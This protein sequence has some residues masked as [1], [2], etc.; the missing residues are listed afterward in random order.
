MIDKNKEYKT[1]DGREVRIYATD[2]GEG[3]PIHGAIRYEKGWSSETWTAEGRYGVSQTMQDL[4]LIEVKKTE[5]IYIHV[6]KYL[7]IGSSYVPYARANAHTI[8][9][10]IDLFGFSKESE[11]IEV[12]E[13]TYEV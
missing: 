7:G 10:L 1:R 8:E 12:I 6:V 3:F 13:K 4:D 5:T 11:L 9:E 2:C